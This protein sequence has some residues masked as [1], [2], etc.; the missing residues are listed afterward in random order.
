MLAEQ[1]G[2]VPRAARVAEI[3]AE[4]LE[5]YRDP[6]LDEKPALLEQRGGAYYSEAA[7]GLIASLVDGTDDVH[8]VDVRNAGTLAGL[9]DDDVVELPARVGRDGPVALE[10]PPLAP[11]LL[12]LVQHVAAYERLAVRAALEHDPVVARKALLAH[13]LIGQYEVAEEL[14]DRL[15]AAGAE[16]L[17]AFDLERVP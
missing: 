1:R 10:Q 8:V 16:H 5:L 9:A 7:T 13:P 17:A 15:L 14:L 12:G 4:L 2:G 11:E 3:E 6:A